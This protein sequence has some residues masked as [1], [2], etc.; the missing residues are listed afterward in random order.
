[1]GISSE[2]SL[3]VSEFWIFCQVIS[4]ACAWI[5]ES[6]AFARWYSSKSTQVD[7]R[8][9]QSISQ[10]LPNHCH[11]LWLAPHHELFHM[12]CRENSVRPRLAEV[13][14]FEY[15]VGMKWKELDKMEAEKKQALE[16]SPSFYSLSARAVPFRGV[17]GAGY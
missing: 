9:G 5:C 4:L 12:H 17:S 11:M 16:V 2:I 13:G 14:S 6:L 8:S 7:F 10:N 15:D 1:M 3:R